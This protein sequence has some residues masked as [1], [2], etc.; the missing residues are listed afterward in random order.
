MNYFTVT[1]AIISVLFG[2]MGLITAHFVIFALVGIF[3]RKKFKETDQKLRYGI[4][5]PTRNEETVVA[6]LISSIRAADY[7]QEKLH[8]FVV[9]H[10]CT[11]KTAEVAR[12]AGATVYEYNNPDER[13]K[14]YAMRYIVDRINTDYGSESFDGFF[15]FDAD[16][17]IDGQY[18]NK[19]NNAFVA[20]GRKSI[21][22]S[23]RS[24]KNFG[25]NVISAMYGLYF[26]YSC[27]FESAGRTVLGCS[28][29]VAGT[30]FL[31]SS[32]II[33]DGW[34]YLS[35]SEDTELTADRLI[36]GTKVVY[37]D[38]AIF[39]DEQPTTVSVM[40][41]QRLRWAKGHLG[42]FSMKAA[43]M[44]RTLFRGQKKGKIYRG[45][46]CDI[47]VGLTP[48]CIV[49]AAITLLQNIFFLLSPLFGGSLGDIYPTYLLNT[50]GTLLSSYGLLL[51]SSTLLYFL[52]R[53][54]LPR[55][56]A[57][58]VI[59]AILLWPIFLLVAA[60]L[61]IIAPFCKNLAWKQ[62]PHTHATAVENVTRGKKQ[63][64]KPVQTAKI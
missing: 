44:I 5:I 2:I 3:K 52:E 20:C 51:I 36:K 23:Y 35:L 28:T 49:A 1:N 42:V 56:R 45:S 37:C 58:T 12:A 26:A 39:Y 18:I 22:T 43:E 34:Q 31:M 62:I 63:E 24:S 41:N 27:R 48:L 32:E 19:M 29:R 30:G 11:D 16:N 46:L 25:S 17:V 38:D 9:A 6:S 57:S 64:K 8:I 7:P 54:K 13:R 59:A 60:P 47:L 53:K 40:W 50:L 21:I 33:K 10:N 61:Q 4:I 55:A 15:V 14:G